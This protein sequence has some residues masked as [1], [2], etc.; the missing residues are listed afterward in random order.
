MFIFLFTFLGDCPLSTSAWGCT[1]AHSRRCNHSTPSAFFK[2]ILLFYIDEMQIFNQKV[3]T[4][5]VFE[6]ARAE[7]IGL[8]VQRLNHSATTTLS[9]LE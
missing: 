1:K 5:M 4:R 8:A 2:F 7:A 3:L 6:P 9:F